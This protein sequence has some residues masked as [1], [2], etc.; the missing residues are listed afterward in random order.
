[1]TPAARLFLRLSQRPASGITT[2]AGYG[3]LDS[4][5]GNGLHD[6]AAIRYDDNSRFGN[7]VT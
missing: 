3:E 6:D 2:N 1:M 5:L 4:D 7:K